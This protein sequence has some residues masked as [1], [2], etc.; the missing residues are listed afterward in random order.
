MAERIT[1]KGEVEEKAPKQEASKQTKSKS[2]T[3]RE[4]VS[5]QEV[6]RDPLAN[7][8]KLALNASNKVAQELEK[9]DLWP[10]LIPLREGESKGDPQPVI[11]GGYR[12]VVPKGK[13]IRVPESVAKILEPRVGVDLI[14]YDKRLSNKEGAEEALS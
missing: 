7:I 13:M 9:E 8:E 14:G 2:K 12:M 6:K 11:I 1:P 5:K 3:K 10:I 4:K